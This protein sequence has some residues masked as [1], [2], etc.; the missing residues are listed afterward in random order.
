[1][2][3]LMAA[4][5]RLLRSARP[6]GAGIGSGFGFPTEFPPMWTNGEDYPNGLTDGEDAVLV[7]YGAIYRTQP[8]IATAVDKL[9][10]RIATLPFDAFKRTANDGR[11]LDRGSS[12]DS[13][14]HKPWPRAGAVHLNSFISS[15]MLVHGNALVAKLRS[16]DRE[17]PPFMLWPLSWPLV[18]AYGPVGGR[19]EWW[20]TTQFDGV[21]RFIA[22][23]DVLHFAWPDPEGG[24]IGV[25]PIQKLGTTIALEAASSTYQVSSM[26]GGN[27]PSLALIYP[28]VLRE[29]QRD[30]ILEQVSNLHTRDG[31]AAKTLVMNGGADVK[32]LSMTPVEAELTTQRK[33]NR[34]EV[35]MVYDLPGPLM[36]DLSHATLA[37]VAEYQKALYRDVVPTWTELIVQTFQAQLIDAEPAWLDKLVR[38]DF[39]D[40]LK[41]DPESLALTLKTEVEAGLVSRNEARQMLGYQPDGDPNDQANP[42]NQLTANVN[43]QNTLSAMNGGTTAPPGAP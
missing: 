26:K 25:S 24:E 31:L 4:D 13:L 43:N 12:L 8:I 11:E 7:S 34:E 18:N 14:I 33:L 17:A 19:I 23:E 21:E 36:N 5:G 29:A 1:M 22:V 37:N 20:S 3:T 10:R 30:Q 39:S 42:A 9:S 27:R 16:S 2:A 38:F 32:T 35:G 40:K 15:S 28:Q 6:G 41:G